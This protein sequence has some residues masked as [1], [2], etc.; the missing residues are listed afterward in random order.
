MDFDTLDKEFSDLDAILNEAKGYSTGHSVPSKGETW[1]LDDID[2]LIADTSTSGFVA[3]AKASVAVQEEAAPAPAELHRFPNEDVPVS[4]YFKM[5]EKPKAEVTA[6]KAEPKAPPKPDT[7]H[8]FP[9]LDIDKIF[10]ETVGN[11]A[12]TLRKKAPVAESAPPAV[13]KT[14]V[15]APVAEKPVSSATGR[16]PVTAPVAAPAA[17]KAAAPVSPRPVAPIAEQKPAAAPVAAPSAPQPVAPV[18]KKATAAPVIKENDT[19]YKPS[20][21]SLAADTPAAPAAD[22]HIPDFDPLTQYEERKKREGTAISNNKNRESFLRSNQ[23]VPAIEVEE[24]P[25][26]PIEKPGIL[27]EKSRSQATSD[28][29]PLPKIISADKAKKTAS[30]K[31]LVRPI[32]KGKPTP[33]P[34]EES[35]DDPDQ[36]RL[37]EFLGDTDDAPRRVNEDAFE[38]AVDK[39]RRGAADVFVLVPDKDNADLFPP[40]QEVPVSFDT[41]PPVKSQSKKTAE[42]VNLQPFRIKEFRKPEDRRKVNISIKRALTGYTRQ[43]I[44]SAV[45]CGALLLTALVP[46]FLEQ[47]DITSAWFGQGAPGIYVL[48]A[49]LLI[50]AITANNNIFTKGLAGLK[51]GAVNGNTAVALSA[52]VAFLH[53]T[54][55][56]VAESNSTGTTPVFPLAAVVGFIAAD[57][58]GAVNSR[59][60][61]RNFELC[62]YKYDKELYAVH[63]FEDETEIRELGRGLL[64]DGAELLYSSEAKFPADFIKNGDNS[65]AEQKSARLLLPMSAAAAVI[66]GVLSAVLTRDWLTALTAFAATFCLCSPICASL[67]PALS[68]GYLNRSLNREGSMV[69]GADAAE[70]I[71]SANAV[72]IDSADIFDRSR[73][74]M[75]GMVDFKKIR[76]DD[77]LV[78]A[79]ALVIKSGGPL[80]DSFETVISEDHG[81]LPTVKDLVYEDKLGISARILGQKVL[82]GS[83]ALLQNHGVDVPDTTAERKHLRAGKNVIYLAVAGNLAAMFVVSYR[84]DTAL[85]DYLEELEAAGTQILVR[86]N[87]VNVTEEMLAKGFGMPKSAF[88]ILGSVAGRLYAN[89]RDEPAE[90]VSVKAVHNGNALTML[91][92][93]TAAQW[94][95]KDLD[96]L[97]VLQVIICVV[98]FVG[99]AV[100]TGLNMPL[101]LNGITVA[102][103][104]LV[105]TGLH[106]LAALIASSKE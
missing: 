31:T 98:G 79:A 35:E 73:C 11:T 47:A 41:E 16:R 33:T 60:I 59:R 44:V 15:A 99:A 37:V 77:V 55:A 10:E 14:P 81:L 64:M 42:A 85:K 69:S 40:L 23:V 26:G 70:E 36:I 78:Y 52:L 100:L 80:R 32:T 3:D 20:F 48:N 88:C 67:A 13:E 103:F 56:A 24:E 50:V 94:L 27:V 28:L 71:G 101:W 104:L 46:V 25:F 22:D 57:I 43:A 96:A 86:T 72:V 17:S 106:A 66:I 6:P 84:V 87:D 30:E 29:E 9:G 68:V 102:L 4:S 90:K 63:P 51:N 89:R 7:A 95:L 76:I 19:V 34:V 2:R 53:N 21:E 93:V 1:S 8:V 39:K 105:R 83:R 5:P 38:Q 91:R 18:T 61:L 65:A 12:E 49:V 92:T 74:K 62:A 97:F 75:H 82:L 45:L 54:V 58:A